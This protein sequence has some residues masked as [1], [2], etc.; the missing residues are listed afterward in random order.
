MSYN[1]S[2]ED[3]VE[4]NTEFTDRLPFG[5][6]DVQLVGATSGQTEAG[7]DYIELTV[8]NKDGIEE[9]ARVWFTGGASQYSFNTVKQIVVHNAKTDADKEKARAAVENCTNTD[10]MA[11]LLNS[12]TVGGQLWVTKYYDPNRTYQN[13]SG[14]TRRSI[15]T[16]IVGY[17]PKEKP[18]LLNLKQIGEDTVHPVGDTPLGGEDVTGKVEVP[19]EWA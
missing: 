18:E 17:E 5:V 11:D 16:N 1:F 4:T 19:G 13:A 8:T 12:K 9:S 3:K 14:Q 15:N 6:N 7:K 2:D 10:E